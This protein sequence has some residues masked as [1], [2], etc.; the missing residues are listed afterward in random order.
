VSCEAACVRGAVDGEVRA[1]VLRGVQ[2]R[3]RQA[4]GP[5]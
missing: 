5:C 3:V 2:A 4:G 1:R